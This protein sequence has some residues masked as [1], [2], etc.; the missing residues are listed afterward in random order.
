MRPGEGGGSALQLEHERG[1]AAERVARGLGESVEGLG[2]RQR[3]PEHLR[4]PVEAALDLGLALTLLE[5]LGV[6]QRE[7][8]KAREGLDD[9]DVAFGEATGLPRADAEDAARLTEPGDRG[10]EH[11]AEDGI[12][13]ARRRLLGPAEAVREDGA[14]RLER[15]ADRALGRNLAADVPLGDADDGPA[16]EEVAV[17]LEDPAVRG[18]G[19]GERHHLL[20]Q[21]T[22]DGLEPEVA[23]QDLRR[24]DQRRLPAQP[25]LVLAQEA[26][27]VDGE[28]ELPRHRLGERDLLREPARGLAPV[29]AEHADDPVEHD[30]RGGEHAAGPELEQQLAAA[31][32]G[33]LELGRRLDVSDGDRPPVAGGEVEAG[34]PGRHV[35]DRPDAGRVPLGQDRHRLADLAEP[36]EG[37]RDVAD[38]PGR[39][40]DGDAQRGVDVELGANTPSDLRDQALAPECGPQRLVRARAAERQGGLAGQALHDVELGGGEAPVARPCDNDEDADDVALREQRYEGGALR[41]DGVGE[42]TVD[43]RRGDRVVDRDGHTLADD[44]H[45]GAAV[46]VQCERDAPPPRLV[47]AARDEPDRCPQLLVDLGEQERVRLEQRLDLVEERLGRLLGRLRLRERGRE[48][49]DRVGFAPAL[50]GDLLGLAHPAPRRDEKRAVMPADEDDDT[51]DGDRDRARDDEP[52]GLA[53]EDVATGERQTCEQGRDGGHDGEEEPDP[54]PWAGGLALAQERHAEEDRDEPVEARQDQ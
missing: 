14:A 25:L 32:A 51:G 30:D 24:F 34:E 19:A 13:R 41:P 37:A 17:G 44:G 5:A 9:L 11:V 54:Q 20:D 28:A 53:R 10:G 42:R 40:L 18:V 3:R 16:A 27:R 12:G 6:V 49:R 36:D 39:L 29:E 8:G 43:A 7:R 50:G 33:V 52:G 47:D 46:R 26:R 4:D 1:V 38:R 2:A 31:Q 23:G 35:P 21:T 48:P 22:D 15:L 45:D